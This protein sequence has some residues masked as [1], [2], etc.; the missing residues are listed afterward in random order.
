VKLQYSIRFQGGIVKTFSVALG[1]ILLATLV[2]VSEKPCS[3]DS[4][5][6]GT[7]RCS[8]DSEPQAIS[9]P[10]STG[11]EQKGGTLTVNNLLPTGAER[12]LGMWSLVGEIQD[13]PDFFATTTEIAGPPN[14]EPRT[15]IEFFPNP[16]QYLWKATLTLSPSQFFLLPSD[17]EAAYSV[18][19][20]NSKLFDVTSD[21][22]SLEDHKIEYF[23]RRRG[24]DRFGR[25]LSGLTF[26]A[27]VSERPR[28]E[29]GAPLP[30]PIFTKDKRAETYGF[31][32]D[33][34]P[35]FVTGSEQASAYSALGAYAKAY[36][37][38]DIAE[39]ITP[40]CKDQNYVKCVEEVAGFSRSKRL[41]IALLPIFEYKSVDQFDFINVGGRFIFSPIFDQTIETYAVT[42]DLKRAFKIS[43]EK[44]GA[45]AAIQASQDISVQAPMIEIGA[46]PVNL[47]IGELVYLKFR[48]NG[49][50]KDLAWS[51]ESTCPG[52]TE[53]SALNGVVLEGDGLLAGYPEGEIQTCRFIVSVTDAVGRVAHVG[54]E[55]SRDKE[56]N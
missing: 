21:P 52:V 41:A 46:K 15:I 31:K 22:L 16:D 42:W 20:K 5:E 13:T 9:R 8:P 18:V 39:S 56:M 28:L 1:G 23:A 53:G 4:I 48:A 27:A 50:V 55:V 40:L 30:E 33:P 36:K 2:G 7:L 34:L 6:K 29:G 24:I 14:R 35:W 11:E 12:F 32:F 44:L 10:E 3:A 45:V 54:C 19:L 51:V 17:L 25:A 47:K 37:R 38:K 49:G 26:S 43:K